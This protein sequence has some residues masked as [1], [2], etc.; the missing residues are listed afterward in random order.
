MN[1]IAIAAALPLLSNVEP[2]APRG[3]PEV[4]WNAPGVFVQ[5]QPY[6]VHITITAPSDGTVV[7]N[8][9]LSA[10]AFTVD[11]KALGKR[12]DSGTLNLPPG[13]KIEGA[14]DLSPQLTDVKGPFKLGYATEIVETPPV[15][16]RLAEAAP[17]GLKFMEMTPEDL[18]GYRVVLQ[19]NRGDIE[20][21]FW[22][23]IAPNHVRNFLDLSYTGFYNGTIFHRVMPGFMIQG[24]DPTGTGRGDGPRKVKAEFQRE[25]SHKR[26]VLSMARSPDPDSASCQF[27]IM[28][29]DSPQLDGSYSAFGE[30]VGGLDV[31][32]KIAFAPGMP[33]PQAGGNTPKEPQKI[34]RAIVIKA[35]SK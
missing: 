27:F 5:G 32:D 19:T 7:A 12:D 1:L 3:G 11:G 2:V 34:E 23:E 33:I 13:F 18:A 6:N 22:P 4:K 31:V 30:A 24:G 20:V 25:R 14:L 15:E 16:V 29:A 10:S 28:H 26:G 35:P 8:W 17:S 21:A 9:L